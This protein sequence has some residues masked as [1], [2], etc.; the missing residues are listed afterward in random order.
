MDMMDLSV[1]FR[2]GDIFLTTG[3]Y[4]MLCM[5][6]CVHACVRTYVL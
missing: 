1:M 3:F 6:V 2:L 4:V 5:Y